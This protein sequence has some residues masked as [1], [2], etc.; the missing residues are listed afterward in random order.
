MDAKKEETIKE[1]ADAKSATVQQIALS[2][3][4]HHANN[5]L[6]IPGT[7]NL[8]HLEENMKILSIQL[9]EEDMKQLDDIAG[10]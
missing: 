4:L 3:L 10:E 9:T 2:W 1:I 6:L 7:S 5:I 8:A